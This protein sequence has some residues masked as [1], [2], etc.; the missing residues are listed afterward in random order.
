VSRLQLSAKRSRGNKQYHLRGRND[1]Q[2]DS[3]GWVYLL[4]EEYEEYQSGK[5]VFQLWGPDSESTAAKVRVSDDE[6][7]G[8]GKWT[9]QNE[10]NDS[11]PSLQ[12]QSSIDSY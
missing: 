3:V 10:E 5:R 9:N 8:L 2:H 12:S 6:V 1:E 11:P 7:E 4:P